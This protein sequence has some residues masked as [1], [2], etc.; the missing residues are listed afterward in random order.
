[1]AEYRQ[2]K[3]PPLIDLRLGVELPDS[4][5]SG[6]GQ[7][8]EGFQPAKLISRNQFTF[9]FG[10]PTPPPPN[11]LNESYGWRHDSID[12]T[13]VVQFRR[14]GVTFSTMKGYTTWANAKESAQHLWRQFCERAKP[15]GV[16]RLAVRY[17][18][19]FEF[20]P[21]ADFDEYLTAGPRVPP[22]APEALISFIHRVAIPF[23]P[24]ASTSATVT[25]VVEQ[26]KPGADR[27]G[28]LFLD[29]DVWRFCSF[30][31]ES[32]EIWA[33]LD[34]LRELKNQ[35]FFSSVTDKALEQYQ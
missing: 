16:L 15:G 33:T 3:H 30:P 10:T 9:Q 18:N 20:P 12:E 23:S 22:G 27:Q 4:S 34:N 35:L 13:R 5:I 32:P 31:A 19:A 8:L 2:L 29:I 25:Q 7:P 11:Q 1:V 24:D 26:P 6:M 21:G 28:P 17:I 14:D